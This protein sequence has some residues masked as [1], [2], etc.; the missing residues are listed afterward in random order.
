[1]ADKENGKNQ[2][3]LSVQLNE[4]FERL[5]KQHQEN[6][7]NP[8]P[9][10]RNA[11]KQDGGRE[12]RASASA[13][14]AVGILLSL[15]AIGIASYAA[16]MVYINL[17][18]NHKEE[19]SRLSGEV[20]VLAKN[21]DAHEAQVRTLATRVDELSSKLN[22]SE[23]DNTNAIDALHSSVEA[24]VAQMKSQLGT[25]GKDWL[26]A[27]VEYLLRLANQRVLMEGD[28]KGAL[29]LFH[30][31]DDIIRQSEG[32]TAFDLRKAIAAN[33]AQ[34]NAVSE[35]DV[36]GIFVQLAALASQVDQLQQKQNKFQPKPVEATPSMTQTPSFGD[37][38]L[39]LVK[40]GGA[41]LATLVDFRRGETPIKPILPPK[42]AYYLRQNLILKLQMAQLALLRSDQA[43]YVDSLGEAKSWVMQ[44][45]DPNDPT[46]QAMVK[47]LAGLAALDVSKKM[48]DVSDSLKEVRKL[49]AGFHQV[50]DRE[51]SGQ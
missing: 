34:L 27:E 11:G 46:T 33:I 49:M 47:S 4:A 22:A 48:P 24:S 28:A 14:G 25:S 32:V 6:L 12:P 18:S 44:Y 51:N 45:F 10:A 42:E 31:A 43:V 36:D 3:H 50:P 16:Y 19:V 9:R 26:F 39:D 8:S 13:S 21:F 17:H 30:E 1:M 37:R 5:E 7:S 2:D 40:R 35:V 38:L 20:Q 15:I 23:T 41:R 29:V